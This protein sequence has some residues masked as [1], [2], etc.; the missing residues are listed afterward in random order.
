MQAHV[1]TDRDQYT[2][3]DEVLVRV[4]VVDPITLAPPR[5]GAAIDAGGY[6]PLQKMPGLR[7]VV[8]DAAG[9]EVFGTSMRETFSAAAAATDSSFA[10]GILVAR[11]PTS[12]GTAGGEYTLRVQLDR[13]YGVFGAGDHDGKSLFVSMPP[14]ERRIVLQSVRD[15]RMSVQLT[16]DKDAYSPGDVAIATVRATRSSGMPTAGASA[17]ARARVG[18]QD[19]W[20]GTTTLDDDGRGTFEV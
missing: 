4:Q 14:S 20:T 11:W 13:A 15:R 17:T 7:L 6:P 5:A 19:V 18:G 16:F 9:T 12:A 2:P 8:K 1:S 10:D 3:G